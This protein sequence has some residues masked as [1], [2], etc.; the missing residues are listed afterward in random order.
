[1]PGPWTDTVLA[2]GECRP[3]ICGVFADHELIASLDCQ[4]V[5]NVPI[6][7]RTW[8]SLN[9]LHAE[10][11]YGPDDAIACRPCG[12]VLRLSAAPSYVHRPG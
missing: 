10:R 7:W 8:G 9:L 5:L 4:S 12:A 2:R 11:W 1:M 3:T 6:R